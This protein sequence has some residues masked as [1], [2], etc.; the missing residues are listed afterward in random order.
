MGRP[1]YDNWA[2]RQRPYSLCKNRPCNG[3][4][5]LK[6]TRHNKEGGCRRRLYLLAGLLTRIMSKAYTWKKVCVLD[7][8]EMLK[9]ALR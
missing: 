2:R 5:V 1:T 3:G 6:H 9:S 4:K 7:L 8:H